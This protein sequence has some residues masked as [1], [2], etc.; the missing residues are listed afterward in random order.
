MIKMTTR[1]LETSLFIAYFEDVNTSKITFASRK[2]INNDR[3]II[4][5][6]LAANILAIF[7]AVFIAAS[8][9]FYGN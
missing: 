7:Y 2:P 5:F 8:I 1:D 6:K 4:G 3:L 9:I